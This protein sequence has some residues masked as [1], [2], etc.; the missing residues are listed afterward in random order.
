MKYSTAII[1]MGFPGSSD[2]K[3]SACNAGDL[4]LIPFYGYTHLFINLPVDEHW[5]V[6]SFKVL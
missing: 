1:S 3:A 4:G 6:F 2:G 5:V